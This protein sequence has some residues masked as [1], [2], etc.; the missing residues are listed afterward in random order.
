MAKNIKNKNKPVLVF[1]ADHRGHIL[2]YELKKYL[3]K[4]N[5][6]IVDKGNHEYDIRDDYPDFAH[7]VTKELLSNLKTSF[8]ILI[9]GSGIGMSIAANRHKKIRAGIC[10]NTNI[11]RSARQDDDINVLVLPADHI[12]WSAAK[13]IVS[14]FLTTSFLGKVKHKRRIK[15]IS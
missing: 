11:A 13:K 6:Q 1:G 12:S 14:V 3:Q 10:W 9:C 15:K 2:K 8:G 5:Y 7:E 4:E